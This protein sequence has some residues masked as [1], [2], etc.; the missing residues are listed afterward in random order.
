MTPNLADPWRVQI[1]M[2]PVRRISGD[3][4]RDQ[5][6]AEK[7]RE[8]GRQKGIQT[9]RARAEDNMKRA[10]QLFDQQAEWSTPQVADALD[11]PVESAR[12]ALNKLEG[13]SLLL[14]RPNGRT[15]IFRRRKLKP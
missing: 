14:A 11:I 2:L 6:A 10:L 3:D 12:V 15:K 7:R 13:C 8:A 5:R 1:A 9:A 4:T